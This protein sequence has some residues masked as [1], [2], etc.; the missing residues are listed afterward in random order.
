MNDQPL[1]SRIEER[2]EQLEQAR[3][4]LIAWELYAR[5]QVE[6]GVI[7]MPTRL[8]NNTVGFLDATAC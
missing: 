1:M 3:K 8:I 5:T 4:L 6:A 7:A 2:G